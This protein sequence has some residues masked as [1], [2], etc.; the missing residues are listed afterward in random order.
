MLKGRL[1]AGWCER[2]HHK[3]LAFGFERIRAG[4]PSEGCDM[5][6]WFWSNQG[7]RGVVASSYSIASMM[8]PPN[9][10]N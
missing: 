2:L 4:L 6:P 10:L 8:A 9:S 5:M 7:K 3:D 1:H